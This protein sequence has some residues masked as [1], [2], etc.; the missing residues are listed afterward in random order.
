M[1]D[2]VVLRHINAVRQGAGCES[3]RQLPQAVP[4]DPHDCVFARAWQAIDPAVTV[5]VDKVET[6]DETFAR[7]VAAEF[8]TKLLIEDGKIIGVKLPNAI[9]AW[10]KEF[11]SEGRAHLID[12]QAYAKAKQKVGAGA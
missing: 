9:K 2:R 5:Q 6:T 10:I 1:R 7:I 12:E 4:G 3:L 8:G 11:D